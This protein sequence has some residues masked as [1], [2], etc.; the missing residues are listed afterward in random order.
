MVVVVGLSIVPCSGGGPPF[1]QSLKQCTFYDQDKT[2]A[3]R[4][5]C[6]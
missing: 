4:L 5:Y 2:I 3:A 6:P 1:A